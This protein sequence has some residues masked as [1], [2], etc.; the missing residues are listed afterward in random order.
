MDLLISGVLRISSTGTTRATE[1]S[2]Q[3]DDTAVVLTMEP[4][5]MRELFCFVWQVDKKTQALA[6]RTFMAAALGLIQSPHQSPLPLQVSS[7]QH[8][9]DMGCTCPGVTCQMLPLLWRKAESSNPGSTKGCLQAPGAPCPP[10]QNPEPA[11]RIPASSGAGWIL[12]ALG[13]HLGIS[14]CVHGI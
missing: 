3:F 5:G 8:C 10:I 12:T 14:A 1:K 9:Q 6:D 11:F 2:Y 7:M 13:P 4:S